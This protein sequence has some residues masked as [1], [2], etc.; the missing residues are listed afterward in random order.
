MNEL[1]IHTKAESSGCLLTLKI[2]GLNTEEISLLYDIFTT[3][4]VDCFQIHGGKFKD[5]RATACL[6]AVD[7]Y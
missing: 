2:G 5:I 7:V 1:T 3:A 4:I 6:C